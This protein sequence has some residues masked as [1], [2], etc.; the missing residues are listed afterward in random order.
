MSPGDGFGGLYEAG[1]QVRNALQDGVPSLH[2]LPLTIVIYPQKPWPTGLNRPLA[3]SLRG[4]ST[5]PSPNAT[6]LRN[7]SRGASD[8]RNVDT[9]GSM[10]YTVVCAGRPAGQ[11]G[12]VVS[13]REP[14]AVLDEGMGILARAVHGRLAP[15]ASCRGLVEGAERPLAI[16]TMPY[17]RGISCLDALACQVVM[18]EDEEARHLCFIRHLA[19]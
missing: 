3:V 4:A 11:G 1:D 13:F 17:L 14:E 15:E 5:L 9:P 10:S 2:L 18:D 12:L 7:A 16:Y 19:R 8:V 6:R